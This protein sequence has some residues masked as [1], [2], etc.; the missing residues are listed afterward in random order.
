MPVP[1]RRSSPSARTTAASALAIGNRLKKAAGFHVVEAEQR[2]GGG[3]PHR[4]YRRG[5]SPAPCGPSALWGE[6]SSTATPCTTTCW[7]P[8]PPCGM[9]SARPS[10]AP[11]TPRA[12]WTGKNWTGGLLPQGPA[13][14][15]QHHHLPASGT[16]DPAAAGRVGQQALCHRRHQPAGERAGPAVRPDRGRHRPTGAAGAADHGPGQHLRAVCPSAH[17]RPSSPTSTTG[18]NAT[19]N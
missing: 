6:R 10:R 8:A 5:A 1:S 2:A 19:A 15:A 16:G 7:R 11:L 14:A 3:G 18:A 17:L 4:R 9:I 12:V 13:G